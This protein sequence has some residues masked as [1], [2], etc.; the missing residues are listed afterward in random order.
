MART[1]VTAARFSTWPVAIAILGC[2]GAGKDESVQVNVV[3]SDLARLVDP[4][5]PVDDAQTLAADNEAFAFAAYPLLM[6]GDDS[7]AT[8][9]ASFSGV[10]A[11]SSPWACSGL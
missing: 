8:A 5:V 10:V 1:A 11:T 6:H 2:G 4:Q 7:T 9:P 3:R